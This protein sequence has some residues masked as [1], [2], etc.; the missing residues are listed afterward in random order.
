MR[1]C[2][3]IEVYMD[4]VLIEKQKVIRPAHISRSAWMSY[5][6]RKA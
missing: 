6:E 3:E 2:I 1:R 4:Y 5:W